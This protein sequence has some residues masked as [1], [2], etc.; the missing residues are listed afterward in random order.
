MPKQTSQ[1]IP[2]LNM[3]GSELNALGVC[4]ISLSHAKFVIVFHGDALSAILDNEHYSEKFGSD[5]PNLTVLHELKKAG[6]K[7]Y[8]CGHNL[9]AEK[10]YPKIIS[11]V[12]TVASVALIVLMSY[13]NDGYALMSF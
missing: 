13:Q 2:A 3:A 8:V 12:V 10:I 11:P 5:N 7:L 9:L 4:N 6:V 1:L